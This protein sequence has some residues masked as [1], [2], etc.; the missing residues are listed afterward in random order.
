MDG[1]NQRGCSGVNKRLQMVV[2][3]AVIAVL[4][5]GFVVIRTFFQKPP[6]TVKVIPVP[7]GEYDPAVW[8]K[9]YPLEYASYLKNRLMSPSPTG[10]GGSVKVQKSLQQPELLMNFKGYP[11]SLDY[12]ED[13]G[14]PYAMEDL[15]ETKRIGPANRHSGVSLS[16]SQ[17]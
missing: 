3:L 7:A 1:E 11:F 8:G 9:N 12:T 17:Q 14:H 15:L 13:R 2:A 16:K 6:E 5:F 4:A 10:Y